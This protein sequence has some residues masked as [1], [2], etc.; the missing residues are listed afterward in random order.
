MREDCRR[1]EP[2]VSGS[3]GTNLTRCAGVVGVEVFTFRRAVV[4]H[5]HTLPLVFVLVR[6]SLLLHW[7]FFTTVEGMN[8]P[9]NS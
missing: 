7:L 2:V 8:L 3:A 9:V 1:R 4:R 5:V 6:Y